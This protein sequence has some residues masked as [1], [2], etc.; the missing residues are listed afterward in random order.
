MARCDGWAK[1]RIDGLLSWRMKRQSGSF[2]VSVAAERIGYVVDVDPA[3]A[4]LD[5]PG[6]RPTAVHV[7]RF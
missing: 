5:H 2:V 4:C 7:D 3:E 6:F 1:E